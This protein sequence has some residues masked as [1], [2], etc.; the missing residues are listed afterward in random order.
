M[1]AHKFLGLSEFRSDEDFGNM[2]ADMEYCKEH[3]E[4]FYT[5]RESDLNKVISSAYDEG[6]A[7]GNKNG[8]VNTL[9]A[10]GITV[11]I[12][13]GTIVAIPELRKV[14]LKLLGFLPKG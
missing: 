4:A 5:C 11:L 2:I 3:G 6:C 8:Q 10:C 14:S 7:D 12:C 13:I 9:I 1:D